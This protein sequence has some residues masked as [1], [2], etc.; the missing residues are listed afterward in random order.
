[1]LPYGPPTPDDDNLKAVPG[2]GPRSDDASGR[3]RSCCITVHQRV[4]ET[5]M[6]FY[7]TTFRQR[8]MWKRFERKP[9]TVRDARRC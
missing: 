4:L 7:V 8:A 5:E 6:P 1:M 3:S 9:T 2:P